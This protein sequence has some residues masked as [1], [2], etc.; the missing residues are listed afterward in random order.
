MTVLIVH[1]SFRKMMKLGSIISLLFILVA[2]SIAQKPEDRLATA[3]GI[4]F[5]AGSLSG[6][7]QKLYLGQ[8]SAVAAERTQLLGSLVG[9]TLLQT[10][11]TAQGVT[12]DAL[13]AAAAKKASEPSAAEIKAVYDANRAALGE[14]PL[15][16]VTPQIVSFLRGGAEQKAI[17]ELV[18]TLKTKH[19]FVAGKDINAADLKPADTIFSIAGKPFT[20]GEFDSRFKAALY[21]IKAEIAAYVQLDLD[22]AIF[23]ALVAQEAKSRNQEPAD[24]LAAEI[25]NKLKDFTDD[26]RA[27]L[28]DGLKQRLFTKY[29]VKIL[30]KEPVPVAHDVTA[31][32]DPVSGDPAAPVTVIM[33]SD[34]QCSACS[35]THPVLKKVLAEYGNKVRLVVRDFPLESVHENAF[36]AALAANAARQQGKFFEYVEVLYSHQDALDAPSLSRYATELGLNLKQFELDS[37]S[38]KTAAE[39]RKD[40]ADGVKN[41][42]G[43]TPTI[44]VNGVKLQILSADG[45][46]NAIDR[47][48]AAPAVK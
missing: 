9:E 3:T 16:Q 46:R 5:S 47:A 2:T 8:N 29:A 12:V 33:F 45:F 18:G 41:G 4:T 28:E 22:N 40:M 21:D 37:N 43:G 39:I 32:D 13:L 38:E 14:R 35:A 48:L 42:A 15:E 19:K 24:L 36:R 30:F 10:E 31:D 26:E 11:A 25:T 1:Q 44:F 17:T 20:A 27:K 34:F 7:V 23:S 6:P